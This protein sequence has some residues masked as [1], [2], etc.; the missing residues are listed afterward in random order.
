MKASE[1]NETWITQTFS[2]YLYHEQACILARSQNKV[3]NK[4]YYIRHV[5]VYDGM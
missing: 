2:S 5:C 3:K 1:I 4:A